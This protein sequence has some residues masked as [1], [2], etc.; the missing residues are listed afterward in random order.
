MDEV[1]EVDD[2]EVDDD[3]PLADDESSWS[4]SRAP[5]VCDDIFSTKLCNSLDDRPPL[6]SLSADENSCDNG[7]LWLSELLVPVAEV[8]S[9]EDVDEVEEVDAL[10][11]Q[12]DLWK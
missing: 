3:V 6:E 5:R 2:D 9:V 4:D 11:Y 12:S 1:E 10:E 8:V 7:S